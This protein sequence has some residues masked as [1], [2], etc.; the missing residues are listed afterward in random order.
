MAHRTVVLSL[1]QGQYQRQYRGSM[2]VLRACMA[3]L[4]ACMAVLRASMVPRACMAVPRAAWQPRGQHGGPAGMVGVGADLLDSDEE[5]DSDDDFAPQA[6]PPPPPKVGPLS[7]GGPPKR[8]KS[9]MIFLICI[10]RSASRE[11]WPG[12]GFPE[13]G[14]RGR[15][16]E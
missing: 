4:R 16:R 10:G 6:P 9:T 8:A 12:P 13:I 11:H 3:V 14:L 1:Q 2:A 7:L 15:G 5:T